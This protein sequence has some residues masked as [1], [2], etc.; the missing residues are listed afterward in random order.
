MYIFHDFV[1]LPRGRGIYPPPLEYAS[2]ASIHAFRLTVCAAGILYA[3]A[4][5][6]IIILGGEFVNAAQRSKPNARNSQR[7]HEGD[8]KDGDCSADVRR[9]RRRRQRRA[10]MC[11]CAICTWY[12]AAAYSHVQQCIQR[13]LRNIGST[14]SKTALSHRNHVYHII[15]PALSV[16]VCWQPSYVRYGA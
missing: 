13:A 4:P 12:N 3:R 15:K 7:S 9:P 14:E 16:C 6:S 8:Y 11:T 5:P 10:T 2:A 1:P